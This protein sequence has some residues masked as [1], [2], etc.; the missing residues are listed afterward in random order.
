MAGERLVIWLFESALL[1]SLVLI[2]G[3]LATNFFHQ[4]IKQIR[5]IQ[6]TLIA[7]VAIPLFQQLPMFPRWPVALLPVATESFASL[8]PQS[9]IQ[10]AV[11]M[12]AHPA[13]GEDEPA[14]LETHTHLQSF[15]APGSKRDGLPLLD[16]TASPKWHAWLLSLYGVAIGLLL[17]RLAVGATMRFRLS[18]S[19]VPAPAHVLKLFHEVSGPRGRRTRLVTSNR[20][21]APATWGLWRPVIMLPPPWLEQK[22]VAELRFALAHE[23]SH[24]EQRD[25]ATSYLAIGAEFLCFY[26]PAFWWIRRKLALCQDHLADGLAAEC[27]AA[28]EEYAAFLVSLARQ[29]T[30]NPVAGALGIF[31][32]RSQL[33]RRVAMICS[34]ESPTRCCSFRWNALAAAAALAV[35]TVVASVRLSPAAIAQTAPKAAAP[36]VAGTDEATPG[37]QRPTAATRAAGSEDQDATQDTVTRPISVSGRAVDIDGRPISGAKMF[38]SSRSADWKRLAET[39]TDADGRYQFRSIPLPLETDSPFGA[40]VHGAFEVFGIAEGYGFGWRPRKW[41][42]PERYPSVADVNWEE[43][44]SPERFFGDEPIELEVVLRPAASLS[45]RVVDST[46]EPIPNTKVDI[47]YCDRDLDLNDWNTVKG[48]NQFDSLNEHAIVPLG[49][50][51]RQT[52]G[53]GRFAFTGLP[54]NCRFRIDVRPPGFPSRWI[55]AV[56]KSGFPSQVA[57]RPIYSDGMSLQFARPDD[58]RLRVV[59]DDT[60]TPA[61][62]VL[63]SVGSTQGSSGGVTNKDGRVALRLADGKQT[64]ELLPAMGTPYLVT[65]REFALPIDGQQAPIELRL[66]PAAIVEVRVIDET[67]GKGISD[68]DLWS[69]DAG[70][71]DGAFQQRR[72][73]YFRSYELET[74]IC[75][76]ER[77]RTDSDGK[78][79]ALFEPGKYLIGV[80]LNAFP[81]GNYHNLDADG[82]LVELRAGET[83]TV[84]FT[85]R[86]R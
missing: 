66:R 59:Y 9:E 80:G 42:Y 53:D 65:H 76:V 81:H 71:P 48:G 18:R 6:W 21:R 54:A 12:A 70:V 25:I 3:A 23:W 61:E 17:L 30:E 39:V 34:S 29:Q 73:H 31:R 86:P 28:P 84:T 68:I 47:R 50:K 8:P 51:L 40:P 41:Y 74:R 19:S 22:T 69:S 11:S 75:H 33:F 62:K 38:L 82:K 85:A 55:W 67:T 64:V 2:C 79:R 78:L 57:G 63:V 26:Q 20:V 27:A 52:D 43:T 45:G 58:V 46:G 15:R 10:L 49:V 5:V 77:P 83:A 56:T 60:G 35:L 72:L 16:S 36:I 4:P 44:D 7:T 24:I 13:A 1:T 37:V 32:Y 14:A